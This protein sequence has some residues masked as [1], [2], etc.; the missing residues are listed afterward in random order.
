M[1]TTV[2]IGIFQIFDTLGRYLPN[3]GLCPIPPARLWILVLLR[4]AFIPLFIIG[5]RAPDLAPLLCGSDLGRFAL[6]ALMST[7]NGVSGSMA[8]AAG[9]HLVDMKDRE[10]ASSLMCLGLVSGIFTGSL[11]AILSQYGM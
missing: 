1:Y 2:L 5:Q 9:P 4:F 10:R 8:M 3:W 7:T 6:M 11:L